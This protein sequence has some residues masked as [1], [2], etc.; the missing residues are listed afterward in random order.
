MIS[1]NSIKEEFTSFSLLRKDLDGAGFLQ[2]SSL[3]GA[4]HQADSGAALC[5]RAPRWLRQAVSL[6]PRHSP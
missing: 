1:A 5:E 2:W 4:L 6:A 3:P